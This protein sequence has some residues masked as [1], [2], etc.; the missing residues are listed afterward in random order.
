MMPPV[1]PWPSEP[2]PA[3][4]I[5]RRGRFTVD[6]TAGPGLSVPTLL[7]LP[8]SGCLATVLK[9]GYDAL[10]LPA[11]ESAGGSV[12]ETSPPARGGFPRKRLTA[13]TLVLVRD[14]VAGWVST[15]AG[16]P[17]R[18]LAAALRQGA[19]RAAGGCGSGGVAGA[20]AGAAAGGADPL[21]QAAISLAASLGPYFGVRAEP[22]YGA[23]RFD[24][25][26]QD[27]HGRTK[28][29]IECKSITM[30][31]DGTGL[32]PDAPTSRGANHVRL[33]GQ[34]AAGGQYRA[35]LVFVVGRMDARVVRPNRE[36]DPGYGAAL[37]EARRLGLAIMAYSAKISP[38]GADLGQEVRVL[39]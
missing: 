11:P 3:V 30:V 34:L 10:Y 32:F 1:M 33:L 26:L 31:V 5:G 24:L 29:F 15:D 20:A 21:P 25:A 38:E 35:A 16:M 28:A 4:L 8:N 7:H 17:A 2:R 13:G 9:P 37:D 18:L 22:R 14:P 6:A 12:T 23:Y 39:Q 19:A 36:I 27:E